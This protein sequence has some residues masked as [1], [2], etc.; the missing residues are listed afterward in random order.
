MRTTA[1]D[2]ENAKEVQGKVISD[3]A[4]YTVTTNESTI[5]KA[6]NFYPGDILEN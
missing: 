3:S 1:L 5:L 2:V 6:Y 4:Q